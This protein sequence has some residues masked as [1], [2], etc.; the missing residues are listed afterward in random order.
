LQAADPVAGTFEKQVFISSD[1]ETTDGGNGGS[2]QDPVVQVDT[3]TAGG[4]TLPDVDPSGEDI[5][6]RFQVVPA[7][8]GKQYYYRVQRVTSIVRPNEPGSVDGGS[9]TDT[10]TDNTD[11]TDESGET[12]VAK[13]SEFSAPS[14]GVTGPARPTIQSITGAPNTNQPFSVTIATARP[15]DI[16]GGGVEDIDIVDVQVRIPSQ[17][18]TA[19]NPGTGN[20][21]RRTFTFP[22]GLATVINANGQ[23]TLNFPQGINITNYQPGD[24]LLVR[25]GLRREDD[26]PGPTNGFVFA[27]GNT[28]TANVTFEFSD[29]I[30][31]AASRVGSRGVR[32][33]GA[34]QRGIGGSGLPGSFRGNGTRSGGFSRKPGSILRPR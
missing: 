6:F 5:F 34:G 11:N 22:A 21:V 30:G 13:L 28:G 8:P 31:A 27:R 15:V 7:T 32:Q 12:R 9:D 4:G 25:V 17:G 23:L 1:D 14:G 29:S 10:G 19:A 24:E 20:F 16:P 18:G 3:E 26:S 2:N 33:N